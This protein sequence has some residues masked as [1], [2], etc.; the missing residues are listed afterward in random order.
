MNNPKLEMSDFVAMHYIADDND[1]ADNDRDN[2]LPFKKYEDSANFDVEVVVIKPRIVP[3]IN[4]KVEA[5]RKD[6]FSYFSG[7][8]K[9]FVKN[10]FRPPAAC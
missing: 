1:D 9:S 3:V 5:T 8:A 10:D 7:N 2:Q 6:R 4:K